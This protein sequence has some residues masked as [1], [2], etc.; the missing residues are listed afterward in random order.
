MAIQLV[1]C[2]NDL[3]EMAPRVH[4]NALLAVAR[5]PG[6]GNSAMAGVW[7]LAEV[8][9][10]GHVRASAY[11]ECA[12]FTFRCRSKKRDFVS[13]DDRTL[14]IYTDERSAVGCNS[15]CINN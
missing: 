11:Q 2:C 8:G 15:G 12:T 4:E 3:L 13:T 5:S 9:N 7:L 1:T 6:D 14:I 10:L